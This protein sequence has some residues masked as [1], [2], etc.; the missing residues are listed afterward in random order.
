MAKI[1]QAH[2]NKDPFL[3]VRRSEANHKDP[4]KTSHALEKTTLGKNRR[5]QIEARDIKF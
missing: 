3:I 5:L 1:S 2:V 4:H